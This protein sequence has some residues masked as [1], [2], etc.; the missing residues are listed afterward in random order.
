MNTAAIVQATAGRDKGDI[1]FVLSREG[2]LL[3]LVNGKS[4]PVERPKSKK[5]RH[6]SFLG[7]LQGP[8]A[9]KIRSGEQ[10]TNKEVRR[11]L[12]QWSKQWNPDQEG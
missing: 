12:A 6:V 7:E 3:R 1:F 4:R 11:T 5:E 9:H 2:S 8:L 10:I